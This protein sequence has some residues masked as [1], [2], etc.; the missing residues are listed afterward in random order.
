MNVVKVSP[1]FQIVI[2][3]EIRKSM[4]IKPGERIQVLQYENRIELVPIK[5]MKEMR[6][7]LKGIDTKIIRESDRI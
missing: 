4:Q 1:K 2:P 7:F 6:G 3:E 5:S